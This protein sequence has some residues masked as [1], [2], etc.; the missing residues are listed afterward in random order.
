MTWLADIVARANAT[1][2]SEHAKIGPSHFLRS[3]LTP[4]MVERIWEHI[5]APT[6]REHY[7]GRAEPSATVLDSFRTT[8]P[9]G[10]SDDLD[11]AD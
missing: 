6:I 10:H 7:Y 9:D 2:D 4:A 1:I 5:V 3:D 8:A 11:D